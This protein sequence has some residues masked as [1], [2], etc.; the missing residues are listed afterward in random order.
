[1]DEHQYLPYF[2]EYQFTEQDLEESLGSD[3]EKERYWA[4]ARLLESAP[5]SDVWKYLSLNEL[6]KVFSKLPLK[7]PVREAWKKALKVWD[8][9]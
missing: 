7:K 5:F 2:W 4:I 6:R 3:N 9:K 8:K 1:M